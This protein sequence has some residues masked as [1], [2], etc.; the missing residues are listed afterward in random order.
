MRMLLTHA[1]TPYFNSFEQDI[2]EQRFVNI[3]HAVKQ[4]N[5]SVEIRSTLPLIQLEAKKLGIKMK[6]DLPIELLVGD[7]DAVISTPSSV[8]LRFMER[9]IPIMQVVIRPGP[10]MIRSAYMSFRE[11][12]DKSELL[13]MYASGEMMVNP[14]L[15]MQNK[16]FKN[17]YY[18]EVQSDFVAQVSPFVKVDD[19][20]TKFNPSI[21]T[22]VF[23]LAIFEMFLYSVKTLIRRKRF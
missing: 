3:M 16:V 19:R 14:R 4:L 13:K 9:N 6:N 17:E 12:D 18:G 22:L 23:L 7:Y 8:L 2:F 1:N 20:V 10:P 15:E 5:L 21:K 11:E